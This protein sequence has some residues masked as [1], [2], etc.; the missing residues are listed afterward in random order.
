LTEKAAK[1][2]FQRFKIDYMN[3]VK[4]A[5][6]LASFSDYWNPRIIGSLNGQHV[7]LAKL[8]GEFVWHQHE[9]EDEFFYVLSGTL[10][11]EFRDKSELIQAGE[12]II[13]PRGVEHRPVAEEEVS[14]MLFEPITTLNT[15]DTTNE[16]TKTDLEEI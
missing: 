4:V 2:G 16:F 15:G 3:K 8:K 9:K 1:V 13:V 6:K 5:E 7:K 12:F 14:I 10:K 11:M